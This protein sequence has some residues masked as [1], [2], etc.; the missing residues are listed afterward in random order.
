MRL[1]ILVIH[2][3]GGVVGLLSGVAAISF[4]YL[5]WKRGLEAAMFAHF[6]ADF[7]LYVVGPA[8]LKTQ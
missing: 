2:I 3:C 6:C 1:P 5:Y 7:L 4:G 8:F